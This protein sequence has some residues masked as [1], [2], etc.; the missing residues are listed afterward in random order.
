MMSKV[1]ILQSYEAKDVWEEVIQV[2]VS[3]VH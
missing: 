3:N 2:L 1:I